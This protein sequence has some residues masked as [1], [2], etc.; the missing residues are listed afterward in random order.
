MRRVTTV[1]ALL[2]LLALAYLFASLAWL[3]PR[4]AGY[5]HLRHT[6]SELGEVGAPDQRLVAWAVF[7]PVG[8]AFLPGAL[9][10]APT[11]PPVAALSACIAI[12]YLVA[13]VFPCDPGSP[14]SGTARQ[15]VHN[16][17]GAVEYVGGGV[18]LLVAAE[19]FGGSAHAPGFAIPSA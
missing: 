19:R 10:L 3:G 14:A 13:A 16:I 15:G 8:M 9:L 12:G 1:V 7:F 11:A 18:A 17:G 4:K 5:R 6:I 2:P